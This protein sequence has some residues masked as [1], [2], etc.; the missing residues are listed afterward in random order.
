VSLITRNWQLKLAALGLAVALWAFVMTSEK[1]DLVV[2]ALVEL[3]GTPSGLEVVGERPDN[4]DVQLHGL[5]TTLARLPANQV[6]ARV[7]LQGA[8]EG[9]SDLRILPEEVIVPPGVIVTRISP[10]RLRVVLEAS[11]ST[12]LVVVPRIIGSPAA[13]YRVAA[14]RAIPPEVAIEGPASRV[15]SLLKIETEPVDL[16]GA[17]AGIDR[18]AN[19][20]GPAD[21]VR[22]PGGRTVRVVVDVVKDTADPAAGRSGA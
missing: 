17:S 4:V 2:V 10:A 9:E 18:V 8:R 22:L 12:K 14:V 19:L 20:V 21:S 11:R 15:K 5:R 1:A 13:G 6:R 3:E 7:S 16:A